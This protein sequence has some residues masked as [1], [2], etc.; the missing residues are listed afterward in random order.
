MGSSPLLLLSAGIAL[1]APLG[2]TTDATASLLLLT[3]GSTLAPLGSTTEATA[4]LLLLT[5]Q[6]VL[7]TPDLGTNW[8]ITR[9]LTLAHHGKRRKTMTHVSEHNW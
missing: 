9:E 2:T 1:L 5:A 7:L 6:S 3:A 8:G 4:S